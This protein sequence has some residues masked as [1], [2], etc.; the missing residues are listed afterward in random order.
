MPSSTSRLPQR[1]AVRRHRNLDDGVRA[2]LRQTEPCS[3][4]MRALRAPSSRATRRRRP[5]RGWRSRRRPDPC[6]PCATRVGLVVTPSSTPQRLIS[7]ISSMLAVSRN[8]LML[9]F[10][11][12]PGVPSAVLARA[13]DRARPRG[14]RPFH[15]QVDHRGDRLVE[16]VVGDHRHPVDRAWLFTYRW[17]RRIF[18][19]PLHVPRGRAGGD[20]VLAC[21]EVRP[22]PLLVLDAY[23]EG[24]REDALACAFR[25]RRT[26]GRRARP[27]S[28]CWC[29]LGGPLDQAR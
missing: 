17:S 20:G 5:R 26:P 9:S 16:A 14:R 28:R 27:R 21:D 12:A 1:E 15:D 3:S 2:H 25:H 18:V 13:A 23:N 24:Y 22:V 29:L 8:S 7:R 11:P 4:Y 6:P 19:E 10:L